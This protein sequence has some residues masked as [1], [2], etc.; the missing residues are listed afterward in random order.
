MGKKKNPTLL[1]SLQNTRRWCKEEVGMKVRVC[2]RARASVCPIKNAGIVKE[3]EGE[4]MQRLRRRCRVV[5]HL[6]WEPTRLSQ[7]AW[8]EPTAVSIHLAI[9]RTGRNKKKQKR[10]PT[11]E[12]PCTRAFEL[13]LCAYVCA[14]VRR[15]ARLW[16]KKEENHGKMVDKFP[17]ESF[18]RV[19]AC[20]RVCSCS[21][22]TQCWVMAGLAT[23]IETGFWGGQLQGHHRAR[24]EHALKS[25]GKEWVVVTGQ[26]QE[27]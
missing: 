6:K 12:S 10:I 20:M 22:V 7:P 14:H 27:L 26:N 3:E 15:Y 16:T 11:S 21:V 18:V 17:K 23:Q 1:S 5:F 13:L 19:F 8:M 4:Q 25:T 24:T 9:F 2:V